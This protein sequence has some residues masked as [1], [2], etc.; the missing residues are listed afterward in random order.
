VLQDEILRTP[1]AVDEMRVV[2]RKRMLNKEE[3]AYSVPL[4]GNNRRQMIE[5]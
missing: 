1:R 2:L 3:R 5:R 4:R